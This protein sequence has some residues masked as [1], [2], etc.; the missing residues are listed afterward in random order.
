MLEN[1]KERGGVMVDDGHEEGNGE[2]DC[3]R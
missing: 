3:V 2:D 1:M